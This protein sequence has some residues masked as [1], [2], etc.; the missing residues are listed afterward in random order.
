MAFLPSSCSA[1]PFLSPAMP[2]PS[3]FPVADFFPNPPAFL[4]WFLPL[5]HKIDQLLD[6]VILKIHFTQSLAVDV[7]SP[8]SSFFDLFLNSCNVFVNLLNILS[9]KVYAFYFIPWLGSE[10]KVKRT[11]DDERGKQRA[12][13]IYNGTPIRFL[14]KNNRNIHTLLPIPQHTQEIVA[15]FNHI[16][17]MADIYLRCD[18]CCKKLKTFLALVK[19][20]EKCH[21]NRPVPKR[22][23]FLRTRESCE[24]GV[25]RNYP[26][27]AKE[28]F[29]FW[30]EKNLETSLKRIIPQ[31]GRVFQ[32]V[33]YQ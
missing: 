13:S 20:F 4:F 16:L 22:A 12:L 6:D 9:R 7:F 2:R 10:K 1:R 19:H 14:T 32:V 26:A 15:I 25:I 30:R 8:F 23:A 27:S 33:I 28:I 11:S 21:V 5:L 3:F 31:Q 18:E 17:S 24:I 29:K